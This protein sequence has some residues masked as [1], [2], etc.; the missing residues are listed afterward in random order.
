[1]G[2][3][4]TGAILRA[5]TAGTRNVTTPMAGNSIYAPVSTLAVAVSFALPAK[6]G[7]VTLTFSNGSSALSAKGKSQLT[8]LANKLLAGESVTIT[9]YANSNAKLAKARSAAAGRYLTS[10]KTVR[11]RLVAVT[12]TNGQS[13]TVA[14]TKQ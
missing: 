4:G 13:A 11:V 5:S 9:G 2:W 12:K 1:M 8:A 7:T 14:T 3:G 10:K 6:S